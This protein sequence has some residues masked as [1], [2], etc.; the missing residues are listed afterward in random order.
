MPVNAR[1]ASDRDAQDEA[2]TLNRV[3]ESV[4]AAK[5]LRLIILDAC[6]DNPFIRTMKRF[7]R[8]AALRS[9][10]VSSGLGRVQPTGTNTLIAYAAKAGSTAEDGDG[11]HSPFTT[12][13]WTTWSFPGSTSAWRSA[14]YAMR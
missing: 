2:I 11:D 5:R 14:G 9:T 12:A 6:R 7:R 3:V 1:L 8:Q 4:D 13:L 10:S